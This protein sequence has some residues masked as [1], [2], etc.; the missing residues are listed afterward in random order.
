MEG[1]GEI[2]N[3]FRGPSVLSVEKKGKN[4]GYKWSHRSDV[5]LQLFIKT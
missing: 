4:R 1:G 3:H 2:G 5:I